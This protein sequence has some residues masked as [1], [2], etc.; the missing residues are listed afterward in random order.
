MVVSLVVRFERE[1]LSAI[2]S[3]LSAE[4]DS[5]EAES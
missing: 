5:P 3:Q 4:K 1:E 2:S